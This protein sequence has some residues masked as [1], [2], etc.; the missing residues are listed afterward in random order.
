MTAAERQALAAWP[1]P[2]VIA[3]PY[4]VLAAAARGVAVRRARR[5]AGGRRP[6]TRTARDPARPAG[7]QRAEQVAAG[8]A[9]ARAAQRAPSFLS[10]DPPD[11]TRLRRLVSKAFTPRVIARLAPRIR[12][13]TDELLTRPAERSGRGGAGRRA[14]GRQ[15]ARLPAAGPDHLRA[16]RGAG[17]GP[18]TG[19]PAGRPAWRTRCSRGSSRPTRV[20]RRS[21]EQAGASSPTTSAS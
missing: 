20:G 7:Q 18:R 5:R 3:D 11:H 21:A 4:P 6:V 13:L 10:L 9:G 1:I 14:R 19:S 2:A 17:R 16:A 8:A 15:P 12:E